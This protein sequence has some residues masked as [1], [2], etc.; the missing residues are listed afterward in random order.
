MKF[1]EIDANTLLTGRDLLTRGV[2]TR[3]R[4]TAGVGGVPEIN[5]STKSRAL[6]RLRVS[7]CIC[8]F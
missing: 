6:N 7:D 8:P 2:V 3:R 1:G 4:R 5:M